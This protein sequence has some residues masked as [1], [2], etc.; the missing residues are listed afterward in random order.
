[1]V[2]EAI[3]REIPRVLAE[4]FRY[5]PKDATLHHHPTVKVVVAVKSSKPLDREPK[6]DYALLLGKHLP[7]LHPARPSRGG[8]YPGNLEV[9][10]SELIRP[11]FAKILC[12]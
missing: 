1:M 12:G 2:V 8:R 11:E 7:P 10:I 9:D 6:Q 5:R 3:R 4:Q